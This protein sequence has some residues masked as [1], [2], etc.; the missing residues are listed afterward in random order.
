MGSSDGRTACSQDIAG[1]R[2]SPGVCVSG[3]TE[4]PAPLQDPP[5]LPRVCAL[6]S[7]ADRE[8]GAP[9]LSAATPLPEPHPQARPPPA[10]A[11]L[12]CG[13]N[14]GRP[15][16]DRRHAPFPACSPCLLPLLLHLRPAPAL[17]SLY[18]HPNPAGHLPLI[19]QGPL[20]PGR[21]ESASLCGPF[22]WPAPT[23]NPAQPATQ[24]ALSHPGPSA[25]FSNENATYVY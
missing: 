1:E 5:R 3:L 21:T 15:A 2:A 10:R 18:F 24:P 11:L 19:I 12:A 14:P 25:V 4:A 20:P 22:T 23:G 16:L 17:H 9:P 8:L 13:R 7:G 6:R